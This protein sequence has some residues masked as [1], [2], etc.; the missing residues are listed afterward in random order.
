MI[1]S[2]RRFRFLNESLK[3][4]LVGRQNFGKNLDRHSPIELGIE[5][6]IHLTHPA[7]AEGRADF[8]AT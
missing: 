7:C 8:V 3:S 5:G 2:G 6:Q 1:Q 4:L